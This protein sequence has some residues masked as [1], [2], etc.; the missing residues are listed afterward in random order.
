VSRALRRGLGLAVALAVMA[1]MVGLSRAPYTTGRGADALLR[2]SWSGRPQRIERCRELSDAELAQRPA[3]MR[4]R[5]EC[6]GRPAR[7]VV[8]VAVDGSIASLDTVTGGGLRGDRAIHMLREFRVA[9]GTRALTIEMQRLERIEE[10]EAGDDE[11]EEGDSPESGPRDRAV[12]EREERMR[13]RQ[14]ALPPRLELARS[15]TLAPGAVA[16]VTYDASGRRLV[17]VQGGG[18]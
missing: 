8:Q 7:Y 5:L 14:E 3:H 2:L 13:E 15:V 17:M 9:P 16:L 1:A 6:E 4:R 12:R 11:A 10:E 18:R